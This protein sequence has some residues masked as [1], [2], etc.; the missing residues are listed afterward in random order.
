MMRS[1]GSA[2]RTQPI[3]SYWYVLSCIG[4]L[5]GCFLVRFVARHR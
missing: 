5:R 4:L 3:T 1:N 2:R